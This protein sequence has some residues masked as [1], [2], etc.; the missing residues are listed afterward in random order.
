MRRLIIGALL[1]GSMT[2]SRRPAT[3]VGDGP[4]YYVLATIQIRIL[5]VPEGVGLRADQLRYA[6]VRR[7]QGPLPYDEARALLVQVGREGWVEGG[8]AYP[9]HT[10]ERAWIFYRCPGC[11]L[12]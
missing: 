11:G 3:K 7:A 10:V 5:D 6:W 1:V 8:E 12:E 4:G 9:A 2:T